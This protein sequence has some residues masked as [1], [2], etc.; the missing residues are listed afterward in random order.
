[1]SL[2]SRKR[3]ASAASAARER[4]IQTAQQIGPA[5]KSAR[6]N[7]AR[8]IHG[9]REWAA[10]RIEQAA[11][12]VQENVAPKVSAALEATAHKI[13]P[14][15]REL[16]KLGRRA[17]RRARA[18]SREVS[19]RRDKMLARAGKPAR[20]WPKALGGLAFIVA[21]V[22][23]I[24]AVVV[25]RGRSAAQTGASD[26]GSAD[27]AVTDEAHSAPAEAEAGFD[28]QVRTP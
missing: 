18:A 15:P 9:A 27:A 19:M 16:R 7:A 1:V 17:R 24:V 6:E 13:E 14:A 22:G 5:A 3:S 11:Q 23:A 21:T 26:T 8:T 4:A 10:P 12:T 20:R 2:I 25:R 28:G